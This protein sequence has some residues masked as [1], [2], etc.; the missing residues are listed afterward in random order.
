MLV[1]LLCKAH[2]QAGLAVGFA[3]PL[4]SNFCL[5]LSFICSSKTCPHVHG[6]CSEPAAGEQRRY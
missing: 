6:G 1:G 5:L 2:N 4:Y 3:G